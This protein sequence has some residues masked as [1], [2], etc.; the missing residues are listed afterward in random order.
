LK[1]YYEHGGIQIYHGDCREILSQLPKA[2][3]IYA[4][5]PFNTGGK[6]GWRTTSYHGAGAASDCMTEADYADFCAEWFGLARAAAERLV[7][8]PGVTHMYRYPMP[9]WVA[10]ISKP[11]AAGFSK[12]ASFAVWEPLAI[13]DRPLLRISHDLVTFDALNH[14]RDGRQDHPCPDNHKMVAWILKHWSAKDELVIDPFLG[15]GTTTWA[16]KALDRRAIGIEIEEKYC[17]IAAKRLSQEVFQFEVPN[18]KH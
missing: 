7:I 11:S 12:L 1:P 14:I 4:D 18:G 13:Y 6:I 8:T 17:E 5:P 9:L 2:D 15:S 16:A 3:L 10:V